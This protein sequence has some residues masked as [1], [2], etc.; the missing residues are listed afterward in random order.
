MGTFLRSPFVP[1]DAQQ[2]LLFALKTEDQHLFFR[3][4]TGTGKSF[5]TAMHALNLS[6]SMTAGNQ[7]TT[8]VIILVPTQDLAVQYHYW[9]TSILGTSIKD[10]AKTAKIVQTLFRTDTE[11]EQKQEQLLQE[12]PNP[13]VII[14]TPTRMLDI[15]SQKAESFDIDNLKCIIL[16][17]ADDLVQPPEKTNGKKPRHP[18][19]GEILL[20]W[21]FGK[22]N[23]NPKPDFMKLIAISAT[24]TKQFEEFIFEKGWLGRRD[25]L[26]VAFIS[27]KCC[28]E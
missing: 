20:D 25:I 6:R 13:H 21:I 14:S 2:R 8:T 11:A 5:M 26:S 16:D 24:L 12:N 10:P 4:E 19:P 9:I 18:T 22:R 1:T 17:E 28:F 15:V 27:S 3:A 23:V 7:P